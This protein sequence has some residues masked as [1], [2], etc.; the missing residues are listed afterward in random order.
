[1]N[2]QIDHVV[3]L[4]DHKYTLRNHMACQK[5]FFHHTYEEEQG[6]NYLLKLINLENLDEKLEPSRHLTY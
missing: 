4:N 2:Y 1:M 5:F 3:F 6:I